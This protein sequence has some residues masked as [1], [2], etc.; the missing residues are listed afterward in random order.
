MRAMFHAAF[1]G[2]DYSKRGTWMVHKIIEDPGCGAAFESADLE[3]LQRL[4]VEM[5]GELCPILNDVHME[6]VLRKAEAATV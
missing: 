2:V 5:E 3:D 6:P 1:K 4:R